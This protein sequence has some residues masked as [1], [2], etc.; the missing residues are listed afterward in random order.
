MAD[1]EKTQ[2]QLKPWTLAEYENEC[3]TNIHNCKEQNLDYNL[4]ILTCYLMGMVD[5]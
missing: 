4:I 2:S 3:N 5:F 1:L